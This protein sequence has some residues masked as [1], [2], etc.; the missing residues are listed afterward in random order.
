MTY[1]IKL[2]AIQD[3]KDF[4]NK[5]IKYYFDVSIKS[6]GYIVD[7]KS[8]MGIFSLNLSEPIELIAKNDNAANDIIDEFEKDI[9]PYMIK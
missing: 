9:E 3:V 4:A 8:L 7:A 2:N 6:A 5:M 1:R